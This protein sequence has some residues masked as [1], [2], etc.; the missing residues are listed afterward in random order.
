VRETKTVKIV[1]DVSLFL[2]NHIELSSSVA[3][4]SINAPRN[5]KGC[6]NTFQ[7]ISWWKE[8]SWFSV[9]DS[10]ASQQYQH[11]ATTPGAMQRFCNMSVNWGIKLFRTSSPR[12]ISTAS[13]LALKKS[14]SSYFFSTFDTH[15]IE[16]KKCVTKFHFHRWIATGTPD[17]LYRFN[18]E[19][20]GSLCSFVCI[21]DLTSKEHRKNKHMFMKV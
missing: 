12:W 2:R 1:I 5:E 11:Y 10:C 4:V 20:L 15:W 18:A 17:I 9:K 6:K 13:C 7:L 19:Y 14:S 8:E 3:S 16:I 21:R